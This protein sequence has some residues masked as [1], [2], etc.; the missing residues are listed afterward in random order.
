MSQNRM[1]DRVRLMPPSGIREFFDLAATMNDVISLSVGEPDF[2]TPEPIRAA[3][4]NSIDISTAYTSNQ[5]LYE[6]RVALAEHLQRLYGVHY[7]PE[8]E[9]LITVGVS[10]GL[11][12]IAL[13]VLNP[14]DEVIMPDPYY[15]AYT[16]CVMIANA[17]PVFVPTYE[18]DGFQVTAEA[19]EA[20]ITPRTRAIMLGFPGNPTGAVL[21][22]EHAQAVV[23]VAQRHDLLIFSDEIYDR[24]VYGDH[25]HVCIPSLAGA[26]DRTVLFGGF[27]K[28]YAMTGWRIGWIA[29]PADLTA[30]ASKVHQY[31][32]LSAP[33]MGQYAALEALHS[34]E[35]YVKAMV[36]EYDRRRR[37]LVDGLNALGLRTVEP[38]G[39]F[40][41]FPHVGHL[42]V[43]SQD[44]ARQLLTEAGVAIIPGSAFGICG[45]GY[46]RVCYA[47]S[48]EQIE[49]AME[50]IEQ[51]LRKKNWL[52]TETNLAAGV[53]HN[54][55][56]VG[57]FAARPDR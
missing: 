10:E 25:Q 40:Y 52:A 47:T 50:R 36:A 14:G 23:E 35:E 28:A 49:Q 38:R 13:G 1:A 11:Q 20:A 26:R 42:G 24:M 22:R 18:A 30:A 4:I 56:K 15:V 34:G 6:L 44:F 51:F 17:Q 54:V 7:N 46:M 29:A 57:Q 37:V 55:W 9:L 43:T 33:T 16:G 2:K 3:A 21:D 12:S 5:G 48:M 27:S 19:V 39:A 53:P 45:E 32:I 41:A 8:T 31:G